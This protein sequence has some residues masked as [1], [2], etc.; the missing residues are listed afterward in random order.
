M[1]F[2]KDESI[3]RYENGEFVRQFRWNT[4]V[5]TSDSDIKSGYIVQLINRN[6]EDNLGIYQNNKNYNHEYWEAWPGNNKLIL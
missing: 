1:V 6:T 4:Q 3:A 5:I 2:I